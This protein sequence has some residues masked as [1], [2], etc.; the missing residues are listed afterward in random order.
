MATL[1]PL[2]PEQDPK[3]GSEVAEAAEAAAAAWSTR[4]AM[5]GSSSSSSRA[6]F[7]R[8]MEA[9]QAASARL[10]KDLMKARADLQSIYAGSSRT[11]GGGGGEA[12]RAGLCS[13]TEEIVGIAL[14]EGAVDEVGGDG[15][16]GGS[17]N[18]CPPGTPAGEEKHS[19]GGLHQEAA[20]NSVAT[21]VVEGSHLARVLAVLLGGDPTTPEKT[22]VGRVSDAPPLSLR[23]AD[24]PP[25]LQAV[26]RQGSAAG[27]P[28]DALKHRVVSSRGA[29]ERRK[30]EDLKHQKRKQARENAAEI[31]KTELGLAGKLAWNLNGGEHAAV[32]T[33]A[34]SCARV[35]GGRGR[36]E[37]RPAEGLDPAEG[38]STVSNAVAEG[39][40]ESASLAGAF[41]RYKAKSSL[42]QRWL[43][44]RVSPSL[45]QPE[46]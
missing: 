39:H 15:G 11:A 30:E 45:S 22:V 5:A 13:G 23:L 34:A 4:L 6:H 27:S 1:G 46:S 7:Q 18:R 32:T 43:D 26:F 28:A 38:D 21:H 42:F 40:G 36:S 3:A 44:E 29:H 17:E 12:T 33:S 31:G 35:V 20:G 8:S 16:G 25:A 37:S 10:E 19:E 14:S 41:H 24:F 2:E 9:Q